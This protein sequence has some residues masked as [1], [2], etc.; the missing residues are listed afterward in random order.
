MMAKNGHW[1]EDATERMKSKG[2]LGK[3]GKATPKKIASGK[4][5]GGVRAK[6]ATFAENAS[7]AAQKRS[8]GK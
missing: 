2:T 8:V 7:K 3:F 4:R 6:E 5:A 1:M